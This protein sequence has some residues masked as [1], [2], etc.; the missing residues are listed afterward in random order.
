LTPR[1]L[2]ITQLLLVFEKTSA[3]VALK[4]VLSRSSFASANLL[5]KVKALNN[6]SIASLDQGE[7]QAKTPEI[8]IPPP[9]LVLKL[10]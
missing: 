2:P 1:I 6:K 9:Q 7:V 8:N 5:P 3:I 10:S 4:N